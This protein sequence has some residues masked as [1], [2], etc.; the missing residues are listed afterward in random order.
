MRRAQKT[1]GPNN[2]AQK[3]S[4]NVATALVTGSN[5]VENEHQCGTAVIGDNSESDIICV[6]C[7]VA[8]SR[9]F[10]GNVDNWAKEVGLVDVVNALQDAGASLD[11]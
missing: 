3:A 5:S 9:Q 11:T 6:T 1:S 7:P 4:Q 2:T 8:S 10:F